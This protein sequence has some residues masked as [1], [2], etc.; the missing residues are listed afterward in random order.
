MELLFPCFKDA[1]GLRINQLQTFWGNW[2]N[3]KFWRYLVLI[4]KLRN[5]VLHVWSFF[6]GSSIM[7][8]C[9][10]N[11]W[12]SVRFEVKLSCNF[13]SVWGPPLE[14]S[15][16]IAIYVAGNSVGTCLIFPIGGIIAGSSLGWRAIFYF[17]G[18]SGII[19]CIL[20]LFLVYDSPAK[21]PRYLLT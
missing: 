11:V 14:R 12:F 17:T 8:E 6:F 19:W 10:L 7:N 4:N 13:E 2:D 21:H 5:N 18:G 15:N 1:G 20:W 9:I 3:N 16:L